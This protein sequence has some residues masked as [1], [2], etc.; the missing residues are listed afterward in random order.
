MRYVP[1]RLIRKPESQI[2]GVDL[3]KHDVNDVI[4][5]PSYTAL[6][7]MGEGVAI[8]IDSDV[9]RSRD[10]SRPVPASDIDDG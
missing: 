3:S 4:E 5:V 2:K 10:L 7:L 6:M 9:L 8:A 1:V